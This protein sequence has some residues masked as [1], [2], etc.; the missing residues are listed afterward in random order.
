MK[1]NYGKASD[2]GRILRSAHHANRRASG[3]PPMTASNNI[4]CHRIDPVY[5]RREIL[6]KSGA[7]FGALALSYLLRDNSSFAQTGPLRGSA[8]PVSPLRARP[9]H[10]AA[11]AK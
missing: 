8:R 4:G 10:F 1:K 9:T 11:K 5:S 7:G 3:I 6:L 2:H